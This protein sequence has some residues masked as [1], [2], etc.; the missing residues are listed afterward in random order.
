[1]SIPVRY[2][3]RSRLRRGAFSLHMSLLGVRT[4][5]RMKVGTRDPETIARLPSIRWPG[6]LMTQSPYYDPKSVAGK[7]LVVAERTQILVVGAGPAGLAA[8]IEA[9]E[10]GLQVMLVDENPVA[11]ADMGEE[12]PLHFGQGFSAIARN[13]NAMTEAFVASDP[14]IERAFEAGVDVRLGTSVWGIYANG[15]SV[16]WMP[17]PVAGLAGEQ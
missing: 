2:P 15:P 9:A 13:R 3:E 4:S 14:L 5:Q 8:A 1:M 16:G 6:A 11:A 7:E 10:R 17:S 12:V